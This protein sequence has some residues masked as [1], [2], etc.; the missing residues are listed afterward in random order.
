[1]SAWRD[2]GDDGARRDPLG[3]LFEPLDDVRIA[4]TPLRHEVLSCTDE[5]R[6]WREGQIEVGRDSEGVAYVDCWENC[7]CSCHEEPV[8]PATP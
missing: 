7:P 6:G 4:V 3:R 2:A 5:C 1:M 8:E